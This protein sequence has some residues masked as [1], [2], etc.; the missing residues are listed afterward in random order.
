MKNNY[1]LKHTKILLL[2]L[3]VVFVNQQSF[4][5]YAIKHYIA[6]APWNYASDANEFI[7]S[8]TSASAVS[9][10]ITKS[11]G[12][13]VTTLSVIAGT[14]VAYRPTGSPV[15]L[16]ANS[17]NTVY[18]DRGLIF[19]CAAPIAV[20]IR[21][22]ESD[23]VNGGRTNFIKGNAAL[24]SYGNEAPGNIFRLGYY[25]SNYAGLVT[26]SSSAAAPVYSVMA[27]NNGT[28]VA[29]NGTILVNLNAGE[30]YLFQTTLGNLVTT[31]KPVV[32]NSGTWG[33]LPG[34]CTDAVFDEIP[35]VRVLGQEYIIIRG[36]GT[37]GTATN[38]PEQTTFVATE[39]NTTVVV[40]NYNVAGTQISTNTYTLLTAG[41]FQTI[42]HG[43]AVTA[44]SSTSLLSDK[45]IAVYSGT[46]QGCEVDMSVLP[47]MSSCTGSFRAETKKF[48][49]YTNSN[50]PYY[51]CV[52][53]KDS[54]TKVFMNGLDL[55]VLGGVRR[56]I[57][58]TGFYLI[59]FTNV[60]LANPVNIIF[61]S[62][63]RMT[64]SMVQQGGG[65]SM[66]A[67]LSSFNDT[68]LPPTPN[69][70]SNGCVTLL[71]AEPGLSPYQWYLND[72]LIAGATGDTYVPTSPGNYSVAGTKPCG[73]TTPSLSFLVGC[74]TNPDVNS[75]NVNTI[76]AGNV[77]TN[78][79]VP[80]GTTYGSPVGQVGNPNAVLPIFNS[81]GTY[82]FTPTLSGVYTF[83]VD[84]CLPAAVAPCPKELLVITVLNPLSNVNP[85]VATNDIVTTVFNAQ[86][87]IPVTGNDGPGNTGGV[88]G[89]PTILT[90]PPNSAG[91]VTIVAGNPVFTPTIG[92][93]GVTTFVYQICENPSGLC[94]PATV[95]VTVLPLGAA[96][97]NSSSDDYNTATHSIAANG[98]VSTNDI[99]PEGNTQTVS[100]QNVT[101]PKGT[102]ILASTGVYTFTP[103]AGFVGSID[104]PYT[105]CDN[106]VPSY[107]VTA[108]LHIV[109]TSI[110]DAVNDPS[111][112][113]AS[114]NTVV[115]AL[116]ALANDT[117][118]N[119]VATTT[120]TNVTPLTTG[121]LSINANGIVTVAANTPSGTYSITYQLC[122]ANP[123]TG[124]NVTPA[125]CDTATATV[126]VANAIDAVADPSVTIASNNTVVTALNALAND[127][128]NGVAVTTTN[129][130]VTPLTTGPLSI[131]ADGIVTV[132]ANTPSGTYSIT[133]QLC[134]A[135][136]ST[137][138]NVSP[139]N[140]DTA[141]AT[142]VVNNPI[143]AVADPSVTVAS[144]N[145]VVT[146]L[147]ALAND[148]LSNIGATTT[149]TN[150]TPL[151]TG[152]LSID[153]DGIVTVAANTPSGTYSITYQLCEANP[154][155]GL[156]VTPANCDT[157]TATVVVANAIDAVADPSVTIASNNTVV[158]ALN[159]LANDTRNG[160]AVTTTNTN[161][162]PLT[163]GPL[164]INAD[165]IVTVAA[166]TPSGTYSITY[167][168]CEANPS[169]GLNVSPANCD[170]A[171]ATVV[172]NN[173]IDAV[174]DPS[175]TVASNNTV[176]TALNA[177]ANDTLSNIGATTT[178][179]NVTPL[180]TGPLSI[181][182]DGIVTVAA[183]TP[184]GTYSIT[185]QLC[186]ANPATGLNVSPANCDTAIATVVVNN[187]ID[188]VANP[189]VT[190]ASN[191]TVVTALNALGNDT[192]S[193]IAATTT[194]TN[195]TP[196]TTGPLS[197]DADG[198]VTVAANTPSGTYSITYQLC[199]ADPSTGL[200]VTPANCDIATATVVV[201]NPI[202]AVN[203]GPTT[204]ASA[205]TPVTVQNVTSN[206]R[207]N[208][209]FV[210]ATNSDVTPITTGPLSVDVDGNLIVAANTASGTYTITYQLC[211]SGASPANC[212][213]ATATVVVQNPLLAVNDGPITVAT[214]NVPKV[215]LNVT[216]NDTLHG[217]LVTDAN[218]NVT[219]QIAGPLSIANN[220]DITLAANTP[221]GT[222]T[223]TYEICEVGANPVNCTTATATIVVLNAIVA[224]PDTTGGLP[225]AITGSVLGNDTLSGIP[226]INPAD[227]ILTT[228][229][230]NLVLTLNPN[231]TITI[232][233]GTP[234]GPQTLEYQIC[235][236]GSNPANCST[237]IVTVNV[238]QAAVD[239]IVD[240]FTAVPYTGGNGGTTTSV[241]NNDTLNGVVLNPA[242][243]NLTLSG[244]APTGFVL[245]S[246]GTITVPA[247]QV[248]GTYMV[249]YQIC[250]VINSGNCDIAN[251]KILI[252]NSIAAFDDTFPTQVPST[253]VGTTVGSVLANNGNGADS[254]NGIAVTSA[255]TDVTPIT[256][257]PLSINADGNL[258]L[259]PNTVSGTYSITYQLCETGADPVNCTNAV[260]TVVVLNPIDAVDDNP[261]AVNTGVNPKVVFNVT[262]NDTLN[263]VLVSPT[264]TNVTPVSSGPLS[265][266]S[267]GVVILA[268]NTPSGS[269]SITYELCE[270]N[271]STG[272]AVTPSNCNTAAATIIVLN[273]I[274]AGND[275]LGTPAAPLASGTTPVAAGS[276]LGND[277]LNGVAVTTTN[278][279][280]T[281]ITTGAILVDANGNVTI[282]ANTPTGAYTVTYTIC[283]SDTTTGVN[284]SP[285][286]CTTATVTVNVVGQIIAGNDTLGTPAA[287]LASG[288]TAVAAGSVLGN[289]TLNGV[290]VTTTN[291]NVT[292]ITTGAILVDADGNVTIA[293]NT[294]TGAYT[295]TYTICESDTTTGV[296]VSPSN[297]TTAT[298]TVNVVGQIIA[299]NDT[300]GTPAAPLA[301][302]TIAV[303]AGS[304]LGNDTLNGVAVTTTNTNVTPI[305]TGA[306]LVDANG[307]VTIAANTPTGAYTVT[308]TICES[309]TTTGVNVSPSNCTTATVTVNVVGQIIAGNDTLG[310]PAAPLASGTTPVAAGS[311]LGNDTLNGVAVTT[312]NTNV[313]PITTG[314]I[315]VDA[316]GNVTIA[317]NTPTGPYTVTYTI[318][319][320]DTTTGVNVSPSNCTTATVTVNVVGQIIAGNDTLGTPAAPL[321]SG[322]TPVAAGSVLGNDTLNGVAVTTT[323]TNVTPI[324]TGPIL[325]DANGNVTIA[326]NTPTGP[327]TVTYTICESDTTTGVNV[328]PS[329]CTTAIITVVVY[330]PI[331]ANDD[332]I[333]SAGGN[334][335]ANDTLN[336]VP[337]TTANTDVTPVTN[338]P[339]SIDADG[340]LTVAPNTPNG[341]YTITYEICEAGAVPV[342]CTTA[343]VTVN[344]V[345]PLIASNDTFTGAG[346]NV[347]GND[348]V[349]GA[350]ATMTNI[351]V[352][353]V[354]NGPLSI[355]ASGNVTLAPNTPS[356]TYIIVYEICQTGMTPANCTT[357]TVTVVVNNII[358]AN[359]ITFP[360]TG[361]NVTLNDTVN[362]VPA[363]P[364]NTDVTPVTSGPLSID[365]NGNLTVAPNTPSGTYTV[366]YEI[367]EVGATP[368][369]CSRATATV[370]VANPILAN[371]NTF[372]STGGNVTGNDTLNGVPVT[373]A[374]TDVT[375]VTNG[376]LSIDTNGN[377]TVAPNTPSG[378]YTITYQICEVGATP[379]NCTTATATVVVNNVIVANNDTLPATGGNVL[380]N[381]TINGVPVT[382]A[383]TDVT[384]VTSG[385]LSIDAN[386]NLT[387]APNTIAGTYTITY[388]VCE[389]G[390]NPL[391]CTTATVTVV[392]AETPMIAIVK[393]A[394]FNDENGDG[395]A[396]AG[397]TI[398]YSFAVSNTGNT[399]LNNVTVTDVL[400]GLILSGNSISLLPVGATNNTAYQGVYRLK[401]SDINLGSVTNQATATGVTPLGLVVSDLSDDSS[402]LSDRP[403][404]LAIQGCVIEVFNAVAPNGSG[405]N[406][407]FRIRGLECYSDNK[408]E[409]YNRW[410]VLVFERTAY[411]NDDRAFRG[412]SEGRVTF[413][414]SE[415]LP[416][417]TYYYILR[418]KDSAANS[419]EKAGYLY[420]NR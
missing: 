339:L 327:Y 232:A 377:L 193:G 305:T 239:A 154:A 109:V 172:V 270:V 294:P 163:T 373:T 420:I 325:V 275:T 127:T 13:A 81:N 79:E 40:K 195:V 390:S 136:P 316:N 376:P 268:G 331:V 176:V 365:A 2:F 237:A 165:G 260:A 369:N 62:A 211:E 17:I 222:Y 22:V 128:R 101:T 205:T 235:E 386:G 370:V 125:N 178:N 174:A 53:I 220:G 209:V 44:Y 70:D 66:A 72:V 39:P 36:A 187:P 185:Y 250:E 257:G 168:L 311:V 279:N 105:T 367:C 61:T 326:A 74:S 169:T 37:A 407:V 273:P 280:V 5:Q 379:A 410:G 186:E 10:I 182:A 337:V 226:P 299:A 9:V 361:G 314:P 416:E 405:D 307:N 202:D 329:N 317:A 25:R 321:A 142:V 88:I 29:V 31:N 41:S 113:I 353:P 102:F 306:I 162:T 92:F 90:Q 177:L 98:N 87:V 254:L 218:T 180:T 83:L 412:V 364:S 300:L 69:V 384:P 55:E 287:P 199:E 264:N 357:A 240:D 47:P 4:A 274:I 171:I 85:P 192:L 263:T 359:N 56:Q 8:T 292:P 12:T 200:N 213:T 276:V 399:P 233:P 170:T 349:N 312:T 344:Y 309:D 191:N 157:A 181:D 293:A 400:P 284:V 46:A 374:N 188:A 336:G 234:A 134:E 417:G 304:V 224:N 366:V 227:V 389:T 35:P 73:L 345:N 272:L 288:T 58:T 28:A 203:D 351:V 207:L 402:A 236:I 388:Q 228:T 137:G 7:V 267:N 253:I 343:T 396:Q 212:D 27:I 277:T 295:V 383:N 215:V 334:V 161:V 124:L 219:P 262:D 108:T 194:N 206:D 11:D 16:A 413:K 210:T 397:E 404:V 94:A 160:V 131:N 6:P 333:P 411:N 96:N 385:P 269:Y 414:E 138:L 318:C 184:S 301:S 18:T 289:D 103:S 243:V 341:T 63:A 132:A 21:N 149:N 319:E 380:A 310:T 378:T 302:G 221:S 258:I 159:A 247:G 382:A 244:T 106:G 282:A 93:T 59:D 350:P 139:A 121:P 33:D 283:E 291:T 225:G 19:T 167:Q 308:Y 30:S 418:Y 196:L 111:V 271:P 230:P 152:P 363:T 115:T 156:N 75:G 80:V 82:T 153:A 1:F 246:N 342:N 259:A 242:D 419:F 315:L 398:T 100:P 179:T 95:E 147:N 338:G 204:I 217:D 392:I 38:L 120:N 84:V 281:P 322:T 26:F 64:I 68:L 112:T 248:S 123:A 126:V 91:V 201:F 197:I 368:S 54:T 3:F 261:V 158:T 355:D 406:K 335:T 340:N 183:N 381:D 362:G 60:Q 401:Q 97:T 415:E 141:I 23:Q 189:S 146:A 133:Y 348:S 48:T 313:T 290:A 286:N 77:A 241:L 296:N 394:V 395:F 251:A 52:L 51:G 164:S 43:D 245:N 71:T 214:A 150:V 278:T 354:N 24:S 49:N 198:I 328:S 116:N 371:N 34:G 78:D 57:G 122:E 130:N 14:P 330:N 358:V 360:P 285:S 238:L 323:N 50:L 119:I 387:V 332:T 104:F 173:P 303:A 145:T 144:N 356:G 140:C 266:D 403:T 223:I 216:S 129:T 65:F 166:N 45:K 76:I 320:S 265:I 20:S 229:V 347:L 107:C 99:D 252:S 231:G 190:V 114:N 297:C 298:L 346:G 155:T 393:T 208:G 408:V 143:D 67:Y 255:N 391:N 256:T 249:F 118:S 372:P 148:T 175:V 89:I 117:L 151:T 32:M 409:I 135:N 110:I 86:V 375:P 42:H 15:S 324:T 352:T